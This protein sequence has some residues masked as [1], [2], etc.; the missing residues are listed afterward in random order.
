MSV[1][2]YHE[3][4]LGGTRH[5][6]KDRLS[7]LHRP[8]ISSPPRTK[9]GRS[10][11]STHNYKSTSL[12][13]TQGTAACTVQCEISS[14]HSFIQFFKDKLPIR[15]LY[16]T[17]PS[18]PLNPGTFIHSCS[19]VHRQ[20]YKVHLLSHSSISCHLLNMMLWKG[21]FAYL[22]SS[23]DINYPGRTGLSRSL[24]LSSFRLQLGV[25]GVSLAH[26]WDVVAY[27]DVNSISHL[28]QFRRGDIGRPDV[29]HRMPVVELDYR[30]FHE[31]RS[32]LRTV[33]IHHQRREC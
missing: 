1:G 11:H 6:T 27:F 17:L 16:H 2:L 14:F 29:V 28:F 20:I 8:V 18:S 21:K 4:S 15:Y 25:E 24:S 10:N 3:V 19:I 7:F 5:A 22:Q 33:P 9:A 31:R 12:Q 26:G 23:T 13:Q 30:R 32:M